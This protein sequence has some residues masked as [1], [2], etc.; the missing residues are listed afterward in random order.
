MRYATLL[1][2]ALLAL[3]AWPAAA[4]QVVNDTPE[5]AHLLTGP[6]SGRVPAAPP[7]LGAGRM[8]FY[9]F[10]YPGDGSTVTLELEMRP[11]DIVTVDRAGARVYGP[12]GGKVYAESAGTGGHPS[13]RATFSSTEAG[14]YTVQVFNYN[15]TAVEF[16]LRLLGLT[17]VAT[18]TPLP[19]GATPS[20]PTPTPTPVSVGENDAPERAVDLA[21]PVAGELPGDRSGRFRYFRVAHPGGSGGTRVDLDVAPADS[22]TLA[23]TGFAV[24]GDAGREV[25]SSG[26]TGRAGPT[27]SATIYAPAGTYLVQVR[28][29]GATTIGFRLSAERVG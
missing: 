9:R 8:L 23:S 26:P 6:V 20:P 1:L 19:P 29:Y 14:S 21:G 3:A 22:V 28:N 2:A 17:T 5:R 25:T 27:H 24:Y 13:E 12:T 4:Q 18:P 7:N 11:G 10:D 16:D 15:V